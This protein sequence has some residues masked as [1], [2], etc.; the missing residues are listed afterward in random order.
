[1]LVHLYD[2]LAVVGMIVDGAVRLVRR[3]G[4]NSQSDSMARREPHPTFSKE[5]L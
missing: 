5:V 2:V 4:E 1:M 3:P